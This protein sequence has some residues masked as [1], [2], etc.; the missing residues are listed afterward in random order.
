MGC[1]GSYGRFSNERLR[2]GGARLPPRLCVSGHI[3]IG[4]DGLADCAQSGVL[5][6]GHDE[7]GKARLNVQ[8]LQS[9]TLERISCYCYK[10]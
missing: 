7:K 1:Y 6:C 3:L 2:W 5:Y 8:L 10:T 9:R 4:T